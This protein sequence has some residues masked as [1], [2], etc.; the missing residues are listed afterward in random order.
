MDGPGGD[1]ETAIFVEGSG[2]AGF[3]S[4]HVYGDG[5]GEIGEGEACGVGSSSPSG[6][7]DG[8]GFGIPPWNTKGVPST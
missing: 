6:G 3:G 2:R 1:R 5:G 4:L 7:V 8:G